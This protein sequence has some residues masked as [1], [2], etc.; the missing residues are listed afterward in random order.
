MLEE[1]NNG[2]VG[3]PGLADAAEGVE[4]KVGENAAADGVELATNGDEG[5]IEGV[6]LADEVDALGSGALRTD[7][8]FASDNATFQT[9][10]S[11]MDPG[12]ASPKPSFTMLRT[13]EGVLKA[14]DEV[15]QL[16][17]AGLSKYMHA[18]SRLC[19]S[20]ASTTTRTECQAPSKTDGFESLMS[21]TLAAVQ[22]LAEQKL[23]NNPCSPPF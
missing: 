2:D 11:V 21:A 19:V 22:S 15:V 3:A 14:P 16:D 6:E 17:C 1:E 9:R 18:E 12:N 13:P 8:T 10:K 7:A 23:K 4:D 20:G 5:A